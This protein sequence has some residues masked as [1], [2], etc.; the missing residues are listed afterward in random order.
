MFVP[1]AKRLAGLPWAWDSILLFPQR[2]PPGFQ[3]P[4]DPLDIIDAPGPG[5]AAG[6]LQRGPQPRIVAQAFVRAQ[7]APPRPGCQHPLG[8]ARLK[9]PLLIAYQIDASREP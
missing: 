2:S 8:L 4:N 9:E 7:I 6:C 3:Q 1:L 5:A